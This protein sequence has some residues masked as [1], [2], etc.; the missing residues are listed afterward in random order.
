MF[1][2]RR[3]G[4]VFTRSRNLV[5]NARH[6]RGRHHQHDVDHRHA[7]HLEMQLA[8]LSALGH[9]SITHTTRYTVLSPSRFKDFWRD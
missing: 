1:C 4:C 3:L 5:I 8:G 7:E 6:D 2:C 9:V